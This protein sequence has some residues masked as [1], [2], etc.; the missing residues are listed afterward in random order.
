[1]N[2]ASQLVPLILRRLRETVREERAHFI[3]VGL[4]SLVTRLSVI[5]FFIITAVI[6]A[7]LSGSEV[8][9]N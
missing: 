3:D 8:A 2:K 7:A 5:V 1:M 6:A 4:L 9:V